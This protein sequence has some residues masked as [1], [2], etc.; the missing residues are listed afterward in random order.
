MI[1]ENTEDI[2]PINDVGE[3]QQP[4]AGDEYE[5]LTK[6]R[7][8]AKNQKIRAE[9]A[10]T[11]LKRLETEAKK[12]K[13]ETP[14]KEEQP[15]EPDYAKLAFLEGKGIKHPDDQKIVQDEAKRLKLPLTDILQM[16]HIKIKIKNASD[17][18]EAEAGMPDS[19]GQGTKGT[20]NSVDYWREK[21]DKDGN[22]LNPDDPKLE[23][24]VV[25]A[26][27][28]DKKR[29]KMFADDKY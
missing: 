11:K 15:D 14:K 18:R 27:I 29:G 10:E 23:I 12:E 3:E 21:K 9:K 17:Q 5:E 26:R 24:E 7:E 2:T 13:S 20:K 1:D 16:E 4:E 25:N 8:L 22:Y 28:Q 6:A 19:S